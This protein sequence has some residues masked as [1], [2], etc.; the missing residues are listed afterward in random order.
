MKNHTFLLAIILLAIATATPIPHVYSSTLTV[1]VFTDKTSY[2]IDESIT[3]YGNLTYNGSP[4]PDWPIAL[5]VQD[6]Y[7]TP[8]VTRTQ[9]NG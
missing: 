8:V 5:E 6:S 7:H 3:V 9:P 2:V 1:T 4:V